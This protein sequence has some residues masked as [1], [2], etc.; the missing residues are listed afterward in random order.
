MW[1][2]RSPW[3]G[4]ARP[5]RVASPGRA[6]AETGEMAVEHLRH[7]PLF[8]MLERVMDHSIVVGPGASV[9]RA[10]AVTPS[11]WIDATG[12]R[13]VIARVQTEPGETD[14]DE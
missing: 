3:I 6:I 13:F 10:P 4:S 9:R 8:D 5:R 14:R 2:D 7:A 1:A 12:D 11:E